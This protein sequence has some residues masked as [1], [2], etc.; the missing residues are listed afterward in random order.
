VTQESYHPPPIH[1]RHIEHFRARPGK[2]ILYMFLMGVICWWVAVQSYFFLI[3]IGFSPAAATRL[4]IFAFLMGLALGLT[5]GFVKSV[6][7][8]FAALGLMF[9]SGGVFWYFGVI[10]EGFLIAFGVPPG[11][12]SW[13]SRVA[14]VLGFLI[15]SVVLCELVYNWLHPKRPEGAVPE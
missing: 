11:I 2:T 3:R 4:P 13:V 9:V 7:D 14:F 5:M 15:G 10:T 8:L 12:A 6:K 1:K